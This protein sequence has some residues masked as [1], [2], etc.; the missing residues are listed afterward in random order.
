MTSPGHYERR[1]DRQPSEERTDPV[2]DGLRARDTGSMSSEERLEALLAERR[3]ELEE[4]AR[5]LEDTVSEV[6]RREE[7][8]RDARISVERVLRVGAADLE[9][10]E[11]ELSELT[12][13]LQVREARVREDEIELARRRSELGAVEL[14]RA[15]VE[16]REQAV[17]ARESEVSSREAELET[18]ASVPD[19]DVIDD[20]TPS[21]LLLFVPGPGYRL[22]EVEHGALRRGDP[23]ELEDV[24]YVVGRMGPSP[25][26]GDG[27]RCAYLVLGPRRTSP[28]DGSS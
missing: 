9:A 11:T 14:K 13:E 22:V 15:A 1:R 3:Q 21:P 2:V 28:S 10:R 26:P 5:R 19:A 7:T 16:L 27:R 24:E 6:A 25:L 18:S 8:V 23:F 12:H 20:P 4:H 17:A